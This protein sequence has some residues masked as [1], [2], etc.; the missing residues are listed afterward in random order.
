MFALHRI[1]APV[2]FYKRSPAAARYAAALA[3]HF[4]SELTL[5]YV[6]EPAMAIWGC[7]EP[8]SPMLSEFLDSR[9]E[10]AEQDLAGFLPDLSPS[11]K[12]TIL[13]GDPALKI[14]EYAHQEDASI[15]VIPTHGYGPFRRFIL[16]S[17]TAKVLHDVECPVL[18]GVHVEASAADPTFG[19]GCI[20][21]AVDLG[22]DS[23]RVLSWAG[24]FAN[25]FGS[26]LSVV[27]ISPVLDASHG[28]AFDPRWHIDLTH[29]MRSEIDRLQNEA[30]VKAEVLIDGGEDVP[31]AVCLAATSLKADLMVIGRSVER[32]FLGR[33]RTNSYAIIRQSPCPVISI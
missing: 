6:L 23:R 33:L 27:H 5:L 4:Q 32:K 20:L 29:Q 18:T 26:R 19:M 25:E 8:S 15:I 9:R 17:V 28:D 12:R 16:G 14:V 3:C 24:R 13:S 11:I 10:R 31:S 1:L 7:L 30:G 22:T 21:C 2:D